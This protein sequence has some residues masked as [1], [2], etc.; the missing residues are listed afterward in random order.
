MK[1]IDLIRVCV[2]LFFCRMEEKYAACV[3]RNDC[4]SCC[5]SN[6]CTCNMFDANTQYSCR[7]SYKNWQKNKHTHT[8]ND[9]L[10]MSNASLKI[11]TVKTHEGINNS[12]NSE[13]ITIRLLSIYRCSLLSLMILNCMPKLYTCVQF[14]AW[15]LF[16]FNVFVFFHRSSIDVFLLL[17][18]FI[19]AAR[20]FRYFCLS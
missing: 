4:I 11:R 1:T 17:F 10:C 3:R 9:R 2:C 19:R 8:T 13:K 12:E 15:V 16:F 20:F 7:F 18:C 14:S 6:F 5:I